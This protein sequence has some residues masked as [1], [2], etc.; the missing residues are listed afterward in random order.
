MTGDSTHA[1]L[2]AR[3]Q[4][5]L[6]S[7]FEPGA[8]GR[9]CV[10]A[11]ADGARIRLIGNTLWSG[12]FRNRFEWASAVFFALPREL[13]GDLSL[14]LSL[15]LVD[16][17]HACALARG[18]SRLKN[19]RR[20]DND[21]CLCYRLA[22]GSIVDLHEFLDTACVTAAFGRLDERAEPPRR[23]GV[24]ERHPAVRPATYHSSTGTSDDPQ[25]VRNRALIAAL[26]DETPE[27]FDERLLSLLA[28]D[29]TYRVAG[30]TAVSGLHRGRAAVRDA[31]LTPLK[32]ALD[33]PV[34]RIADHIG[35][36]GEWVWV[37]AR[38]LARMRTGERY[39]NDYCHC[40]R[41]VDGR[42]HEA[43]EYLDTELLVRALAGAA[44]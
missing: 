20:Y 7:L 14:T 21:Y 40:L 22:G 8:Y 36:S 32:A 9:G 4:A 23:T 43:H 3:N 11:V 1:A 6:A 10:S 38:G 25:A 24:M 34:L 19:G 37:Q 18:Q 31:M 15:L 27:H 28:A 44:G 33:G 17:D 35:A 26:F 42:I 13:D 30:S 29:V 2:T 16:G 41:L 12:N 5:L 39:D